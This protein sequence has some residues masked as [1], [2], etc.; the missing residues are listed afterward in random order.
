M[1]TWNVKS[2][3]FPLAVE[4]LDLATSMPEKMDPSDFKIENFNLNPE[5]CNP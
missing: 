5:E 3:V 2:K 4:A 1:E